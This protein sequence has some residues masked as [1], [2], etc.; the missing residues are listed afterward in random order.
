M[1]S[2]PHEIA[3]TLV[4]AESA[5]TGDK[6]L[7]GSGSDRSTTLEATI[8]RLVAEE[9]ELARQLEVRREQR[10][11]LYA[12]L[13]AEWERKARKAAEAARAEVVGDA[14]REASEV[15]RLAG[16]E[17]AAVVEAG[18]QRLRAVEEDAAK[19]AA[20]LDAE[21]RA[22]SAELEVM[23]TLFDEL[24]ATLKLVA[25]TSMHELVEA[26]SALAELEPDRP[27]TEPQRRRAGDPPPTARP[28][29]LE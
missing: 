13:E 20:E 28:R 2:P 1:V 4:E 16:E 10:R 3:L 22:K 14:R 12:Q 15:V 8:A 9:K 26:R 23:K 5:S 25:E 24:Q 6:G 11:T 29:F 19:R 7:V 17:A 18:M 21:H 27:L